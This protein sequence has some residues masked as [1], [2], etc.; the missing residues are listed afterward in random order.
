[1]DEGGGPFDLFRELPDHLVELVALQVSVASTNKRDH[2]HALEVVS[3]LVAGHECVAGPSPRYADLV[4]VLRLFIEDFSGARRG[5]ADESIRFPDGG[6]HDDTSA[7][8]ELRGKHARD[9]VMILEGVV[10]RDLHDSFLPGLGEDEGNRGAGNFESFCDFFL[11][12]A[13]LVVHAR[14]ADDLL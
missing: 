9:F 11:L 5:E 4:T 12:H 13:A 14:N 1:M 10:D 2:M 3:G 6:G 7:D 8:A